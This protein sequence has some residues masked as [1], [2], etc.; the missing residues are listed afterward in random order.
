MELKIPDGDVLVRK[1][2]GANGF[3]PALGY[4]AVVGRIYCVAT[5]TARMLLGDEKAGR[6]E[7]DLIDLADTKRVEED[8]RQMTQRQMETSDIRIAD[9]PGPRLE[10]KNAADGSAAPE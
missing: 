6:G 2:R 9:R 7:F 4:E 1:V 8:R 3:H 10:R 5:A